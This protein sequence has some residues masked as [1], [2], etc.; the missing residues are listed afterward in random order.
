[1]TR[2]TARFAAPLSALLLAL[3][4]AMPAAAQV[5]G[6]D[7]TDPT[8]E[9]AQVEYGGPEPV[10][11]QTAEGSVTF[12]VELAETEAARARGLMHRDELAEDEGMLFDFGT[13]RPV[14]IW[15]RNTEIPLDILYVRSDGEIAK[16]VANAQPYSERSLP[17][18]FPVIAV[19]EIAGG[20][21]HE[22]GI[23]PGD[24]VEHAWF[25][26]EDVD[27]DTAPAAEGDEAED[28]AEADANEDDA[29]ADS[30]EGAEDG[31]AE[32]EPAE[33]G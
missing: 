3:A 21:A 1:M 28:A 32:P 18:D 23:R 2:H 7:L 33:Q 29:E 4:L 12:T 5:A 17:S 24:F 31:D 15:M 13:E 14:S 8:E 20:Q 26:G 6:A 19:L 10:T 25:E 16:I 11:V 30:E 27:S 9:D 22:N